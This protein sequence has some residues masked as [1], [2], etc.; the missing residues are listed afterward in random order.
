[1]NFQPGDRVVYMNWASPHMGVGGTVMGVDWIGTGSGHGGDWLQ[2][3][4][5][6]DTAHEVADDAAEWITEE[7]Y[8]TQAYIPF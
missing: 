2:L 5:I 3:R 6:L 7:S 8:I 1:M 4:V